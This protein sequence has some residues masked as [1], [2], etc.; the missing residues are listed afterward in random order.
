M[1]HNVVAIMVLLAVSVTG[2]SVFAQTGERSEGGRA[3][4]PGSGWGDSSQFVDRLAEHLQLDDTQRQSVQNV[5]A[6]AKPEMESLRERMQ[7][8]REAMRALDADDP[9]RAAVLNDVAAQEGQMVTEGVLLR[10]RMQT[11]I[12]AVLNDEQKSKF[13][14]SRNHWGNR[15]GERQRAG[16]GKRPGH[17]QETDSEAL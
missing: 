9:N 13:A 10:E 2:S 6:A 8:S 4:M 14:E 16:R 7:A 11:E 3:G 1:R 17:N 5:F 15:D 12:N